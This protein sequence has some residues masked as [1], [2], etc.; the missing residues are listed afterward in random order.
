MGWARSPAVAT[1]WRWGCRS[2]R[3]LA[4]GFGLRKGFDGLSGERGELRPVGCD[5]GD[6]GDE[7]LVEG[8]DCVGWEQMGSRAGA[9]D[10]VEDD[11]DGGGGLIPCRLLPFCGVDGG[12]K[13]RDSRGDFARAEHADLD[14]G[15]REVGGEVV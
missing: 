4:G 7:L 3:D 11:R 6:V 8:L 1:M 5:P 10:G 14:A 12:E 2:P 9:E 13:T 15:G